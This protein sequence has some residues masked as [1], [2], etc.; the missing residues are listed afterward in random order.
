MG[1]EFVLDNDLNLKFS[2]DK[3]S[4]LYSNV[5]TKFLTLWNQIMLKTI[6][7]NGSDE[8]KIL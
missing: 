4:L 8:M 3:K 6:T 7:L 1:L 5:S 2:K